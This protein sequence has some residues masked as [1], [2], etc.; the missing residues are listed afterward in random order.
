MV[1]SWIISLT[2]GSRISG[3]WSVGFVVF[4][5][6]DY[7]LSVLTNLHLKVRVIRKSVVDGS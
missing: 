5:G 3:F 2:K 6:T 7:S 4:L 1:S